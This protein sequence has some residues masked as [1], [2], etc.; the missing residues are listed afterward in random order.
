LITNGGSLIFRTFLTFSPVPR[1]RRLGRRRGGPR[2]LEVAFLV[3]NRL[4]NAGQLVG[5]RDRKHV[6]VQ[7]LL[8]G[9]DPRLEPVA[10]PTLR[11]DHHHPGRLRPGLLRLKLP[12]EPGCR[13]GLVPVASFEPAS[14]WFSIMSRKEA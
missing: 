9:F 11:P 5:K 7:P 4:R 6:M 10:L 13:L 8:G 1:L 2:N 14:G 12:V 3:E